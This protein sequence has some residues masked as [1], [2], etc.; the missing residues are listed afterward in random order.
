MPLRFA[1]HALGEIFEIHLMHDADA[2][3]HDA[4]SLERLLAP[5]EKLVALAV[6]LEFQ[7]EIQAQGL[8][9]SE[10][11][12]LH[13]VIHHEIHRH[14]RLDDL[15]IFLQAGDGGAHRRQIDEQRH[16]GEVLQH[17]AR[18]DEGNLLLRGRLRIP[19][20]QRFDVLL[21]DLLSVAIA[22]HRF[23]DDAD[24]HW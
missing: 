2:R 3:R 19:L 6:A 7:F 12:H 21:G 15:R 16:T 18:D 20:G 23:Q 4:E 13:R 1:Q 17:D 14:E 9:R 8:R 10:E 5:L 24:A 11:I 22:Q